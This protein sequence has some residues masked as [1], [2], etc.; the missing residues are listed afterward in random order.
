MVGAGDQSDQVSFRIGELADLD[1]GLK[2]IRALHPGPAQAFGLL[3]GDVDVVYL[4]EDGYMPRIALVSFRA[5]PRWR[6]LIGHSADGTGDA[7]T[8]T[9]LPAPVLTNPYS[10]G[11]FGRTS[12][13]HPNSV[14]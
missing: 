5:P 4:D 14:E 8:V 1:A 10:A 3:E 12:M 9:T 6:G 13:C 2:R 7:A 11:L